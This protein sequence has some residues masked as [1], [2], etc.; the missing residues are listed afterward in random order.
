MNKRRKR[1]QS[2]FKMLQQHSAELAASKTCQGI[3]THQWMTVIPKLHSHRA[4]YFLS[5]NVK[6]CGE[7]F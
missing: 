5:A 7:G 4:F 3:L 1:G 6:Y 2:S